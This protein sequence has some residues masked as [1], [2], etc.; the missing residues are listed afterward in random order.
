MSC[1]FAASHKARALFFS[2]GSLLG[3]FQAGC[4]VFFVSWTNLSVFGRHALLFFLHRGSASI[5]TPTQQ[6]IDN[7]RVFDG[8]TLGE[9]V[10]LWI[11]RACC[12]KAGEII[13]L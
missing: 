10:G 9:C 3:T 13:N 6:I 1:V 5:P 2:A 8:A 4:S 7:D 11:M 12:Q